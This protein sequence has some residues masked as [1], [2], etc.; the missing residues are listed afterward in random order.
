[1]FTLDR[2]TK[3]TTFTISCGLDLMEKWQHII[4]MISIIETNRR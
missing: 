4:A 2:R 3:K 1:M